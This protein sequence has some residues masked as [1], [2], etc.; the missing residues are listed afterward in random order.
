MSTDVAVHQPT[1]ALAVATDQQEFT[2]AQLEAFGIGEAT[3]GEQLVFLHTV[4]RTGLDP[5]ARQIYMVGRWDRKAG[6]EKFTIQ[7][8]IDG[9]RLIAD[10]TGCYVGSDETWAEGENGWPVSATVTVKK[11]V[12]GKV[13]DFTAT[14]HFREYVQ[15]YRDQG[16]N[17]RPTQM[18]S[19]MPHRMIAKCAEALA[20]RKAF[21]Q[22][23]SGVYTAEEMQQAD[24]VPGEVVDER[25]VPQQRPTTPVV[26][27]GEAT[28][29]ARDAQ[30]AAAQQDDQAEA[31]GLT[32][33]QDAALSEAVRRVLDSTS[34]ADLQGTWRSTPPAALQTDVTDRIDQALIDAAAAVGLTPKDGVWT[35]GGLLTVCA[36]HMTS[37][38]GMRLLDAA[39]ADPTTD[40]TATTEPAAGEDA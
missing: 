18:W 13:W 12:A 21:P 11:L 31:P 19:K 2:Q 1:G 6:R 25:Q 34:V 16:G 37:Q 14:A 15:T 20:L 4:Q 3:R 23:L 22:E 10:R 29:V 9:Y 24:V 28:D 33:E 32:P 26:S 27:P 40:D 39:T 38:G 36:K 5:A 7:T 8:G 30:T 35:L 17:E